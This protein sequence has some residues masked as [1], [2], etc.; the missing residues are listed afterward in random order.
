[1]Q[2][3]QWRR[4]PLKKRHPPPPCRFAWKFQGKL[5][6]F[7]IRVF[8]SNT[9]FWRNLRKFSKTS[10]VVTQVDKICSRILWTWSTWHTFLGWYCNPQLLQPW[11]STNFR[12]SPLPFYQNDFIV[13]NFQQFALRKKCLNNASHIHLTAIAINYHDGNNASQNFKQ[14]LT[15]SPIVASSLFGRNPFVDGILGHN[16]LL[17]RAFSV[18]IPLWMGF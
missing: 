18:G 2:I 10:T 16:L 6:K 4:F 11:F 15:H 1:M 14:R 8:W 12:T 9:L 3:R 7:T 5:T 17:S 13:K